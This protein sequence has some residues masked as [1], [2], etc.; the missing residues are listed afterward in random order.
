MFEI[1]K[2]PVLIDTLTSNPNSMKTSADIA[3]CCAENLDMHLRRCL[4]SD[5]H[6]GSSSSGK[7]VKSTKSVVEND[8][9]DD[10]GDD[11]GDE[12][13]GVPRMRYNYGDQEMN[14][15]MTWCLQQV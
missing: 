2:F 11:D 14:D 4:A 3:M 8:D 1:Q 15:H 5:S 12:E 9:S 10:D 6:S 7:A 13:N